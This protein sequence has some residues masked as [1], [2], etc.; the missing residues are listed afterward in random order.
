MVNVLV[1]HSFVK[2]ITHVQN[3]NTLVM[4]VLA[5][6]TRHAHLSNLAHFLLQYFVEM[7]DVSLL[8][9]N[10]GDLKNHNVTK[11]DQLNVLQVY[12][13]SMLATV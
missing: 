4:M 10:V 9:K 12:V 7:E 3:Q 6:R 1:T 5:P 13:F 2:L 11:L 8:L